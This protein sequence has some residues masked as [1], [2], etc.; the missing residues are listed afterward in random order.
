[1]T[2]ET[3]T[4]LERIIDHPEYS[5]N[6]QGD[7]YS[8]KWGR[9]RKLKKCLS[10]ASGRA[11]LRVGL[12]SGGKRHFAYIHQLMAIQ[13]LGH[14]PCGMR[15]VVDHIDNN[16]INNHLSNLQITTTR[17][18]SIKDISSRSLPLGV[19][20]NRSKYKSSIHIEGKNVHLGTFDTIEEASMAY[21]KATS[22]IIKN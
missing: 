16:K 5:I 21:Q 11:Y 10:N 4:Q 19:Y 9:V 8:H 22:K 7:V 20:P 13:Y 1:M 15:D 18:N 14:T 17:H 6:K 12:S 3:D 2:T